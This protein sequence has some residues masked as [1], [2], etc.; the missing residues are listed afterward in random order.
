MGAAS[1]KEAK[2]TIFGWSSSFEGGGGV[3]I[4]NDKIFLSLLS[5]KECI[6]ENKIKHK[7]IHEK[8]RIKSLTIFDRHHML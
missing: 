2:P 3:V 6:A 8:V 4:V 7:M 5:L 1:T